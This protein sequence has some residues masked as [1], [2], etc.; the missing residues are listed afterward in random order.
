MTENLSSA[1]I[2]N[3]LYSISISWNPGK[4]IGKEFT[5]P[6]PPKRVRAKG[7]HDSK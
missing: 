6:F 4:I 7:Y 2:G 1:V 5:L 3:A